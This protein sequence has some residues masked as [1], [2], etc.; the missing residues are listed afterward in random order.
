MLNQDYTLTDNAKSFSME[1][2]SNPD[3][4]LN[5]TYTITD[6]RGA[7]AVTFVPETL[8]WTVFY[9]DD[10]SLSGLDGTVSSQDYDI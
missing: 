4:I 3:C 1:D 7:V 8:T 2:V 6:P 10:L 9:M 5:Y